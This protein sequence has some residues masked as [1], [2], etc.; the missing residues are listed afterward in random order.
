MGKVVALRKLDP[1]QPVA[2]VPRPPLVISLTPTWFRYPLGDISAPELL[3]VLDIWFAL[4]G[5]QGQFRLGIDGNEESLRLCRPLM[6][7]WSTIVRVDRGLPPTEWR[8]A[9][10]GPGFRNEHD[11]HFL[12]GKV[13]QLPV[14]Q[15]MDGIDASL[16]ECLAQPD[17]AVYRMVGLGPK[18]AV[19]Y[20]SLRLPIVNPHGRV[21]SFLTKSHCYVSIAGSTDEL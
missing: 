18:G 16:R 21:V 11:V 20:D 15:L 9:H 13:G 3:E 10:W 17:P 7:G 12:C 1:A 8:F 6:S 14:P 19:V 2:A 4:A 5:P